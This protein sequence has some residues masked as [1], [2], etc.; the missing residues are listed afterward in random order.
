[1]RLREY[2]RQATRTLHQNTEERLACLDIRTRSGLG[3]F[4]LTHHAA[5]LPIERRLAA[6]EMGGGW[7]FRLTDLLTRDLE[8][9][10]LQPTGGVSSE[11]LQRAHPLGLCYVLGGSRLGSRFLLKRLPSG[12]DGTVLP[13]SYLADAPDEEIWPWTMSLLNSPEADAE[14]RD[15]VLESAEIA[16]ASFVD[17]LTLVGASKENIDVFAK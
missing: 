4:L 1:M 5:I 8:R 15:A 14:P 11:K 3:R 10:G 9:R 2:L 12:G 6:M 13:P 16:F 17:A 7:P